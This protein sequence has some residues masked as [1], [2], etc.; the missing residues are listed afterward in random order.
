M[1]VLQGVVEA[2]D[3]VEGLEAV[4]ARTGDLLDLSRVAIFGWSYGGY[5]SLH[6]LIKRPDIFKVRILCTTGPTV[7]S[8]IAAYR[9]GKRGFVV[10]SGA[11]MIN[12]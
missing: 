8:Y 4:A 5:L 1:F 7:A 9:I 10:T 11:C 3:Q 2:D 12:L 6:G